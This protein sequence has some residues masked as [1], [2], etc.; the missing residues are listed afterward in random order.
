MPYDVRVMVHERQEETRINM[1]MRKIA[2]EEAMAEMEEQFAKKY[3]ME[4]EFQKTSNKLFPLQYDLQE[5]N[6]SA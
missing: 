4:T 2:E 6:D 5:N 3:F 1:V